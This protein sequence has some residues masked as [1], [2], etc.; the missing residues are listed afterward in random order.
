VSGEE[1]FDIYDEA[2]N[3][4]GQASRS[5]VHAK[6]Y[7][8]RTFHCWLV[9]RDSASGKLFIRFQKRQSGKDTFPDCYDITVAGHLK[10]GETVQDAAREIE[11]EIGLLPNFAELAW[12]EECREETK[13]A[14]GGVPFIDREVSAVYAW[15]CSASL[16]EFR[17]QP[18]ELAGIYEADASDLIDV[19]EGRRKSA[20]ADGRELPAAGGPMLPVRREVVAAQFVERPPSYYAELF[21]ALRNRYA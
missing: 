9:R 7:W 13:G 5:E 8:H 10:A 11:E 4:L 14:A 15:L 3:L 18:E 16:D 20:P 12:I 21:R 1:N 2:M 6:G 17:L 19:F